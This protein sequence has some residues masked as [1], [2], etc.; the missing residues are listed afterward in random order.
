MLCHMRFASVVLAGMMACAVQAQERAP[1]V[2]PGTEALKGVERSH[3]SALW[4]RT[5]RPDR[6]EPIVFVPAWGRIVSSLVSDHGSPWAYDT[7][8][9]LILHGRGHVRPGRYTGRVRS[10]DLCP[11]LSHLLGRP[12]DPALPGRA[13]VQ[14]LRAGAPPPKAI[15]TVVLDQVGHDALVRDLDRLPTLSRLAAGGAWFTDCR[16]DYLPTITALFHGVLATGRYPAQN[17]ISSDKLWDERRQK[18]RNAL[19]DGDPG[20]IQVPTLME[21]WQREQGGRP[22][23]IA[24]SP[25]ARASV[26]LAGHRG[27]ESGDRM[28]VAVW[29]DADRERWVTNPRFYRMPASVAGLTLAEVHG[30][31]PT[32][33]MGHPLDTPRARSQSPLMA[34][35]VAEGLVRIIEAERIGSAGGPT[36]LL[37]VTFKEPDTAGHHHG[38]GSPEFRDALRTVDRELGRVI[39]ALERQTGPDGLVVLVTAD[40]GGLPETLRKAGARVTEDAL[41][42]WL[43]ERLPVK[44]GATPWLRDVGHPQLYLIPRGLDSNGYTV[45]Q[46]AR[47][48]AAHPALEATF[49][50]VELMRARARLE[51]F[52]P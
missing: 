19:D 12:A 31:L 38:N 24:V 20:P 17:G 5:W 33:W 15:L 27:R 52:A 30:T 41:E 29:W 21:L 3:L 1:W 28:K 51:R 48:L 44:P 36:D 25:A 7:H 39:A 10:V 2:R 8:T 47:T 16:V 46:I 34:P 13:Q 37:H 26:G 9:P 22:R 4:A 23:V 11:T 14:V 49:T 42:K 43:L 6:N 32:S 35:L 45:E 50:G 18:Y 40:H